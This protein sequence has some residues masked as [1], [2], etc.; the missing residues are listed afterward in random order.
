MYD[1]RKIDTRIYLLRND[2]HRSLWTERYSAHRND[3]GSRSW[4]GNS[5]SDP[6]Q[7]SAVAV[8]MHGL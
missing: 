6:P 5:N 4:R 3:D 8:Y 7:L 1:L 2:T